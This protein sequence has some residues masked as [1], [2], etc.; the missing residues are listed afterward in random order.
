[1]YTQG[2]LFVKGVEAFLFSIFCMI[3]HSPDFSVPR[4]LGNT[5]SLRNLTFLVHI[6]SLKSFLFSESKDSKRLNGHFQKKEDC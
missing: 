4:V 5:S 3:E 2:R 6:E 1:M